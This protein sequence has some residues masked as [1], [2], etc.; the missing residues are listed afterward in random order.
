MEILRYRH[1]SLAFVMALLLLGFALDQLGYMT[2]VRSVFQIIVQP[3]QQGLS[4]VTTQAD[5]V[6]SR[7][8]NIRQMQADNAFLKAEVDRLLIENIQL[9]EIERENLQ[10]RE[11]LNFVRNNPT[12]DYQAAS[13]KGRVIGSDPSN[14]LYTVFIDIG[15]RDGVAP[16]MP[17]I[18]ER[19]LVGR[20]IHVNPNSAQVLLL[21][22]PASSVN[23]IIQ[24]TRVEG[25]VRGEIGGT[26]LMERIPQGE[27]ISPG[28]LVLT[29]GLGGT[30]PDKLVI[31]QI[32]EVN[33]QDL[34]LFQTARIRPTVNFADLETVLVLTG[35]EAASSQPTTLTP[36]ETGQ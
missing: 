9:R 1:F 16:D 25:L 12:L 14:L 15:V 32:I 27:T 26:L 36:S 24:N 35:F 6:L 13:V 18:T 28:D 29:S 20:V 33:Q 8:E 5:D 2:T 4:L 23:A 21:I 10:L 19:G 11:L 31:G 30:F 22:D 7:Q 34:D 17:V 3:V